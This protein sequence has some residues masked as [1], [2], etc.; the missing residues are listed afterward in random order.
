MLA[1]LLGYTYI[2]M[3]NVT[4]NFSVYNIRSYRKAKD[5]DQ[6]KFDQLIILYK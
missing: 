2:Y 6:K 1:K 5:T 3:N 4:Y